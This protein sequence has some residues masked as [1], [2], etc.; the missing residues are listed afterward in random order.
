MCV[1]N[2]KSVSTNTIPEQ[3]TCFWSKWEFMEYFPEKERKNEKK[4]KVIAYFILRFQ[5]I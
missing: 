4:I 3:N 5:E 2:I 1:Y